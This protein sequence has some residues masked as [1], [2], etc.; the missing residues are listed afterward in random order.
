MGVDEGNL[1]VTDVEMIVENCPN[2]FLRYIHTSIIA[3][4]V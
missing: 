2:L 1:Q 3:K 4:L